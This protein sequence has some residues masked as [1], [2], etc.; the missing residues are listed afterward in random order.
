[1]SVVGM[2]TLDYSTLTFVS[3]PTPLPLPECMLTFEVQL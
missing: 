3:L 1:M 2:A